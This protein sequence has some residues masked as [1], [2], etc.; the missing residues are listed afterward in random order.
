MTFRS[1]VIS[2]TVAAAAIAV[3]LA[4][5]AS[6]V[7]TRN[8]LLHAVDESLAENASNSHVVAGSGGTLGKVNSGGDENT[9]VTGSYFEIVLPNGLTMPTSN[10]PIDQTT[11]QVA[12]GKVT[13]Q[14]LRTITFG[15]QS[16][17]ELIVALPANSVVNCPTGI[18][19]ISTTAAQL[20][21]VDIAGQT[22]ELHRL[23]AT[24]LFVAAGGLLLALGL[25]LFLARQ[26]LHPLEEVTNEIE[27]VAETNDLQ[28]RLAEGDADELGRLR[29]VFNRLLRSV[30]NSQTLQ[31]QL[32]LDASHELRTPLTSL[33]T[34]AQV[35]SRA[36][37]LG[38]DELR[39]ITDDMITQVDE[40]AAL[41]T[42]LGELSRG[43]RSEGPVEQL[44][45]D[46]CV[47]ECVE[48]A[49]TYARLRDITVEVDLHESY[50]LGRRDRLV[51]AVSNLL[52]NAVKFAP[53]NGRIVVTSKDGVLSVSDSGPGIADEDQPFIFDRF[54][55]SSSARSLP[56]SG[57]G[58]AIVAQVV[59]EL[60]GTVQ[61]DRDPELGGARF[62]I[63]LPEVEID[64]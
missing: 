28:Y 36:T 18:C 55:R 22:R 40:L 39:Q 7:T 45:L 51:R 49:R 29:R 63:T 31:R 14:V 2:A 37:H 61:V 60:E 62:T 26:A 57:L 44:R 21:I 13:T 27:T 6:F 41:V 56:G 16:Y 46:D 25:G 43:E 8:A 64:V 32:V 30:E 50:V 12:K 47:E 33:R 11:L 1:R 38:E 17:R 59:D 23:V 35:L 20:F 3:V 5:L 4:C 19:Q 54:W 53:R 9:R 42:D 48:T 58:L 52:T 34:N 24:L 15:G 10:V